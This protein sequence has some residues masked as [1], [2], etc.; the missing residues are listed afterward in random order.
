MSLWVFDAEGE[1]WGWVVIDVKDSWMAGIVGRG[2]MK[3]I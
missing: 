3:R 1:G 2:N